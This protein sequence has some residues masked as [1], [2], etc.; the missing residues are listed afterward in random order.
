MNRPQPTTDRSDHSPVSPTLPQDESSVVNYLLFGLSIPERALRSTTAAVGGVLNESSQLLVP[1]SFRDSKTYSTFIQQMLDFA[2]ED[3]GGVTSE[4]ENENE[5]VEDYV[6]KKAV[7]SFIDL[8]ALPLLHVS[9]MMVLAIVSD[10]AYGSQA[11]LQELSDELKQQGVIAEDSTIDHASDLLDN[12]GAASAKTTDVLDLPPISLE[13]LRKTIRQTEEAVRTIDPTQVIPQSEVMRLWDDMHEIADRE[14]VSVMDVSSTMTMYA[15]GKV[16][17]LGRGAL[18][19]VTIAGNMFD[20]HILE[21]YANGLTEITNRGLYATLADSS[22][23]Y[24]EA[25]WKNFSADKETLT[26]EFVSGRLI[27]RFCHSIRAWLNNKSGKKTEE[28][29]PTLPSDATSQD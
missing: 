25:M 17:N 5:N 26:E 16:G 6:A 24:V 19:T 14:H 2:V 22:Q 8:A 3:I 15:M 9:P 10:V 11:Y 27:R 29:N 18:S 13:G 1:Q 20:K 12:I 7:S 4:K 21:H 23:P 28:K